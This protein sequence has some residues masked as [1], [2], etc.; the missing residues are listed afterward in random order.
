MLT[1]RI[2]RTAAILLGS[3]ALLLTSCAGMLSSN[4]RQ[5]L[6]TKVYAAPYE[7][8]FAASRDALVNAGYLIAESDFDGGVLS[9]SSQLRTHDPNTALMW[10]VLVTPVGDFYMQRY[11]WGLLDLV[12]WPFSIAWAAPSNYMLARKWTKEVNGTFSFESLKPERTRLRITLTGIDW[13]ADKY[14]KLIRGL[15]EEVERQLFIKA[16]DTLGERAAAA[17]ES[18]PVD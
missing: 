15:Q 7:R 14:P 17:E 4:Q 2:P 12:L 6:E 18:A 16:G 13:D 3:S 9:V 5:Q 10:S 1:A 11:A 8:T